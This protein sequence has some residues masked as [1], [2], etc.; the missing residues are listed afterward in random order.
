MQGG[1]EPTAS[2]AHPQG[3]PIFPLFCSFAEYVE[4]NNIL[5]HWPEMTTADS[6][7]VFP[8]TTV[9]SPPAPCPS[10][11]GY[12]GSSCEPPHYSAVWATNEGYYSPGICFEGYTSGCDM[13]WRS[14]EPG[15]TAV[16]CV[17]RYTLPRCS[18]AR[19]S[20]WRVS[21]TKVKR[22]GLFRPVLCH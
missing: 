5:L 6:G 13:A 16:I 11:W 10:V 2:V 22:V 17:P 7:S 8:L 1:R 19:S 20:T 9:W 14:A 15:E 18:P 21:L 3:F 4:K 12:I